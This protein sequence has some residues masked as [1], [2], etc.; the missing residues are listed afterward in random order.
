M[1]AREGDEKGEGKKWS[2]KAKRHQRLGGKK[3]GLSLEAFAKAKSMPSGFN[4]SLISRNFF[5]IF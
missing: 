4:P 3:G 2:H 5:L 1:K